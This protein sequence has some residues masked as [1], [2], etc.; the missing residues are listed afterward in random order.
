MGR[1]IIKNSINLLAGLQQI[2][3]SRSAF[4]MT[5]T[6]IAK[7]IGLSIWNPQLEDKIKQLVDSNRINIQNLGKRTGYRIEILKPLISE[8][9][10]DL[11][12]Q[13]A[14]KSDDSLKHI[15]NVNNTNQNEC[16]KI[17]IEIE[18]RK[19]ID[20]INQI[21]DDFENITNNLVIKCKNLYEEN[22]RLK[23]LNENLQERE[24]AWM[25][26]ATLYRQQ[27]NK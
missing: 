14:V 27:I 21:F 20:D 11:A 23:A 18:K 8:E 15:V 19:G 3:G 5:K 22:V 2:A 7:A 13:N 1:G 10:S 24:R 9:M 16:E 26:R 25:T 12:I 17:D 6:D 4:I